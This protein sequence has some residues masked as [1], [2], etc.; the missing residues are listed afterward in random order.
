MSLSSSRRP[1]VLLTLKRRL[2]NLLSTERAGKTVH[3]RNRQKSVATMS[4]SPMDVLQ[5]WGSITSLRPEWKPECDRAFA[6]W[7]CAHLSDV[8]SSARSV[9]IML[10]CLLN[11]SASTQKVSPDV[12]TDP[13][14]RPVNRVEDAVRRG[15]GGIS[16]SSSSSS[17]S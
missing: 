3:Q 14:N 1:N 4:M 10:F 6:R 17:S 8:V 9:E 12:E 11:A 7:C 2:H 5:S 16:S 13:E 15:Y